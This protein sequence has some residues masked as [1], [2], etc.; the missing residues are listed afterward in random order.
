MIRSEA[1]TFKNYWLGI[2]GERE[3]PFTSEE[4]QK[5][6]A[7]ENVQLSDYIWDTDSD[8]WVKIASF[9]ANA[10]G[11][12]MKS[13]QQKPQPNSEIEGDTFGDNCYL[14]DD[15]E[16][17][18]GVRTDLLEV[19]HEKNHTAEE[20]DSEEE[21]EIGCEIFEKAF[22]ET[23]NKPEGPLTRGDLLTITELQ[24]VKTQ[25]SDL[26]PLAGLTQL[27]ELR[28]VGNQIEDL[29]P[30]ARLLQLETLDLAGNQIKDLTPLS[31]L[32]QLKT[33][34]LGENNIE[35]LT[36]LEGLT[37]LRRLG[38]PYFRIEKTGLEKLRKK[39]PDC[40]ILCEA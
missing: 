27:E 15:A 21:V 7:E 32:V 29:A 6:I 26:T 18:A 8:Q 22:R 20:H 12:L 3:G 11:R 30:L 40:T 14:N 36:P 34:W 19:L 23:L 2:N 33:L 39:L 17:L 28:L 35:D 13:E 10:L 16:Q 9:L 1:D 25:I 38:V 24:L 37:Q 4:V 31:G 5:M